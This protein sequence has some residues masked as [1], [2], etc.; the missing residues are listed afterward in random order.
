MALS[1]GFLWRFLDDVWDL[2]PTEDRELFETYWLGFIRAGGNLQQKILEGNASL[3]VENVPVFLTERWNKYTMNDETADIFA[4]TE[5]IAF[6]GLTLTTLVYETAFFHTLVVTNTTSNIV[7]SETVKFFDDSVRN[8]RYGKLVANT[9]AVKLAEKQFTAGRDFIINEITGEIQTTP[10]SRIPNDVLISVSYGHQEYTL[11]LDYEVDQDDVTVARISGTTIP[12]GVAVNVTYSYNATPT[13]SLQGTNG[14]VLLDLATFE[15]TSQN[16]GGITTGKTL[17]VLTGT[18]VGTYTIN[19]VLTSTRLQIGGLFLAQQEGD[20]SYTINAFPHAMRIVS[21]IES[22]PVLQNLITD[23]EV[24][25]V[26]DVDFRVSNGILASRKALPLQTIGPAEKR[27]LI[28]WAE[29]TKVDAQTPYRNFGVLIDFF[30]ENSE[31][32]KLALQGLWYTF[33]TGS[34][35]GNLRTGLHILMGLPYARNAGSVVDVTATTIEIE[36]DR[37]QILTYTIPDSLVSEVAR[38]DTVVRFERLT[39]GVEI[40]DRI[41]TPGFVASRLGRAGIQ[42]FLTSNASKGPGST[43]ETKAL[44][45]LENHLYLPRILAEAVTSVI[46]VQ[47][48]LTYLNNMKPHW[49]EFLFSFSVSESET[50]TVAEDGGPL[51]VDP[52]LNLTTSVASNEFNQV[53]GHDSHL[54]TGNFGHVLGAGSQAAG[55]FEDVTR[56]FATAGIGEG[57][58]IRIDEGSFIGFWVVLERQSS[59]L[60]SID[61]PDVDLIDETT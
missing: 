45:L 58:L 4:K 30:R 15:D 54:L 43:D 18:N 46:S 20:I 31:E 25:F 5:Q 21:N 40:I 32:Y 61:I 23:P 9:I 27:D 24:T 49:T 52:N 36:D 11:D 48:F 60:L 53:Q 50:I 42:R 13:L 35:Q 17:T 37:G 59:T 28:M 2:L 29:V 38:G 26:E 6:S 14:A 10:N 33:W 1:S 3:M 16:F 41:N 7:Y 47:E 34:T 22:I 55:N 19:A 12:D 8:L 56:D 44:T 57:S 39:N 51:D